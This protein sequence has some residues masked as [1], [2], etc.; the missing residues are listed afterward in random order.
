METTSP[1]RTYTRVRQ[2]IHWIAVLLV[3]TLMPTGLVMARTLDDGLRL[4]LYQLHLAIGWGVVALAIWRVVLRFRQRV[5]APATRSAPTCS[6][7]CW[8]LTSSASS[9][10]SR[11]SG[12]HWRR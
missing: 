2:W 4:A 7:P 12:P 10:I 3:L 11:A 8:S 9:V 1:A 5:S 6:R